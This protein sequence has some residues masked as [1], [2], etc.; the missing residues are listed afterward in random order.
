MRRLETDSPRY[1]LGVMFFVGVINYLDRQVLGIVQE[2]IKAEL[3]LSDQQLG[4]IG[5]TFGLV[6]AFFALPIGR[7]GDRT[8]R[9]RVLVGCMAVWSSMTMVMGAVGSFF[10]LLVTRMGVALGEAGVTPT[11]YSMMADKFPIT[12]RARAISAI[13]IGM[14]IGIMFSN[15]L[16][17]YIADGVGWRWTF[18]I[19]GLPGVIL[20]IIIALTIAAPRQGQA[21]GIGKVKPIGFW[22]GIGTILS[23]PTYRFVLAGATLNSF[24][25]YGLM[26]WMPSYLR[27]AFDMSA[28]EA[29]LAFGL[30]VGVAGL[31]GTLLGATIADKLAGRDLRWYG[32]VIAICYALS[33]PCFMLAFGG[34][35]YRLAMVLMTCGLFLGFGAGACVN[36]I[37][38]TITPIQVRGMA[39]A[40]KTWGLSFLGYGVGGFLIGSLSDFLNTGVSGEG[41]GQALF[42]VSVAPLLAGIC[43]YIS[44]ATMREDIA[45]SREQSIA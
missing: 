29:G 3:L 38:Q 30:I 40:L 10:S 19:F 41:L 15:I 39:A 5:L 7:L 26:Q 44:T 13:V 31:T 42:Y 34:S 33:F 27:R 21:D 37:I 20:A 17:G 4:M 11:T 22:K 18:V 8:S 12:Q 32:W 6:H 16:G 25:G 14:P 43:F 2:D 24:F 1:F 9:K 36:A 35:D 23:I 45:S 28:S